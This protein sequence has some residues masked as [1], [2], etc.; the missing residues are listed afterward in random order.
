MQRGHGVYASE[1]NLALSRDLSLVH[2]PAPFCAL[3]RKE[4]KNK[5]TMGLRGVSVFE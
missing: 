2:M 4:K 1:R 5:Y 3:R